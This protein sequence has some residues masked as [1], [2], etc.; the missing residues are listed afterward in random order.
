MQG[1]EAKMLTK[2]EFIDFI[3]AVQA[4]VPR[5]CREQG[6]AVFK[7]VY[8]WD[9]P[10]AHG[11]IETD[12]Q[13]LGIGPGNFTALPEYSGDMHNVIETSHSIVCRALQ[14][15][16]NERRP[17]GEAQESF[18][19]YTAELQR[20]FRSELTPAW[21]QATVKRLFATTLPAVIRAKG[22]YA[23]KRTR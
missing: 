14:K 16:I 3:T 15:Y 1:Q 12:F 13:H 10:R 18:S 21:A 17:A 5:L 4:A 20:L 2:Q 11:K 22:H 19:T 7:P 9:N 23:D 6:I 8:S